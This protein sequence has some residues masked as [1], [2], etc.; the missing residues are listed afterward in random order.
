MDDFKYL[1]SWMQSNGKDV[2]IRIGLAWCA[3][4]KM[5]RV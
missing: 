4:N 3:F 1:G 5:S 2:I